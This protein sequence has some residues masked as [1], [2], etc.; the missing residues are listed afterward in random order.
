MTIPFQKNDRFYLDIQSWSD[1]G[2][3][4]GVYKGAVVLVPFT[5]PGDTICV[6]IT[7][8]SLPYSFGKC[9]EIIRPSD[10]RQSPP[11][12]VFTRCGGCHIQHLSEASEKAMKVERVQRLFEQE[13][14]SIP[15]VMYRESPDTLFYRNKAQFAVTKD[16]EGNYSVG[17]FAMRSQRVVDC[18]ECYIQDS[19]TNRV[20][21]LFKSYLREFSPPI[22]KENERDGIAHFV[23]RVSSES[24]V[25]IALVSNDDLMEYR[26]SFVAYM[27][28][29]SEVKSI[30]LSENDNLKW[31][32]LGEKECL[33]WGESEIKERVGGLCL[34]LSLRSFFQANRRGML[35]LWEEVLQM[36]DVNGSESVLDLYCGTGAMTLYLA[37]HVQKIVGVESHPKAIFDANANA[38]LNHVENVEFI[39]GVVEEVLPS[40]DSDPSIVICDPPRKGVDRK[41]LQCILDKKIDV[42][43]YVSCSP[44]TLL[45]DSKILCEGGYRISSVCVLNMFPQTYHLETIVRFS[46]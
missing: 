27:K 15:D 42:L 31:T 16:E 4:Q 28:G 20:L 21:L 2:L 12:K 1:K 11:C 7:K 38:A 25:M 39:E 9:V 18:D 22:F 40:M 41:V 19:L 44:E 6:H 32:V 17:F 5:C 10:Q 36:M 23:V 43:I 29:V 33:L 30:Y 13:G 35:L 46:Y 45:R 14:Y 37:S 8:V 34:S 3:G 26:E 24:E